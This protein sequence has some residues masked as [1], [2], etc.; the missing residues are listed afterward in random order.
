MRKSYSGAELISRERSRQMSEE[1]WS[2]EHD[3]THVHG[4]MAVAAARYALAHSRATT[5]KTAVNRAWRWNSYWFK[6]KDT[7]S[8]LVRAGAL[9]AA[10]IDR[11]QRAK[12]SDR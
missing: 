4:E 2:A 5:A 3:D 11:L 9:I 1:G 6:P 10:E 12:R 7:I 8:N